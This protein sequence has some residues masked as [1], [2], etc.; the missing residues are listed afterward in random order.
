[1]N[2]DTEKLLTALKSSNDKTVTLDKDFFISIVEMLD[3][4]NNLIKIEEVFNYNNKVIIENNR[5]IINGGVLLDNNNQYSKLTGEVAVEVIELKALMKENFRQREML[6]QIS[7]LKKQSDLQVSKLND[8][9]I[10]E[11]RLKEATSD[12]YN[13]YSNSLNKNIKVTFS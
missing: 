1:M 7:V 10:E 6:K 9:I 8:R 2:I 12:K 4:A 11:R 13:L 5:T 3:T